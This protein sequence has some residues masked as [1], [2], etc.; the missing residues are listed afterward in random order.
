[1]HLQKNYKL[2][3]GDDLTS[4]SPVLNELLSLF[5]QDD[6][7][8]SLLLDIIQKDITVTTNILKYAN[9]A[10]FGASGTVSSLKKAIELIGLVETRNISVCNVLISN[11][12]QKNYI[13]HFD[14]KIFW[15]HSFL[16]ANISKCIAKLSNK[17]DEN[18]AYIIGLLHDIGWLAIALYLP[19]QY[20][21]IRKNDDNNKN[22]SGKSM[23]SLIGMKVV[24]MWNLPDIICNSILYHT[25]PECATTSVGYES[26]TALSS[27]LAVDLENNKLIEKI[28]FDNYKD[29]NLDDYQINMIISELPLILTKT[30]EIINLSEF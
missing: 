18:E 22:N 25:N 2:K 8:L 12:A 14:Y 20:D 10:Y 5:N 16:T 17:F 9:S 19:D 28:F 15:L 29:L 11:F 1:M 21:L 6:I 7:S 26:L 13:G 24:K 23:H 30:K 4:P 27:R 3:F